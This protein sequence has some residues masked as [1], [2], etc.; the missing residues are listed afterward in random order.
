MSFERSRARGNN[1]A[2]K[3]KVGGRGWK[4]SLGVG[5]GEEEQPKQ[6]IYANARINPVTLYAN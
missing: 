4:G 1:V 3:W 5:A 2:G 6:T